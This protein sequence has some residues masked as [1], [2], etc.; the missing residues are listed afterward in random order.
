[1]VSVTNLEVG[2]KALSR[3]EG[4]TRQLGCSDPDDPC[5]RDITTTE[6]RENGNGDR[7][8][9]RDQFHNLSFFFF[10]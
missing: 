3:R 5:R 10:D 8:V 9:A 2:F 1:M 6:A 4:S 7:Y